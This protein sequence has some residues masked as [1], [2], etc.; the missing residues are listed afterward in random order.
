MLLFQQYYVYTLILCSDVN[1]F[2]S[3]GHSK[4]NFGE[5]IK[6]QHYKTYQITFGS[7]S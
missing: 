7:N 6:I 5:T 1:V 2:W 4:N 3:V